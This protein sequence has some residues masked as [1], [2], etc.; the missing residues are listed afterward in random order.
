MRGPDFKEKTVGFVRV[1][2]ALSTVPSNLKCFTISE[3]D[4]QKILQF[5]SNVMVY[6]KEIFWS[7]LD[8]WKEYRTTS[9]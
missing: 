6:K 4:V 7:H 8:T 5:A 1:M 3:D 9:R 2:N